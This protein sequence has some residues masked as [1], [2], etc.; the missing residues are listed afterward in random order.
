MQDY[1][2]TNTQIQPAASAKKL[3]PGA[4]SSAPH[5]EE[6][7]KGQ[8]FSSAVWLL[9]GHTHQEQPLEG[10]GSAPMVATPSVPT[11][12]HVRLTQGRLSMVSL[13]FIRLGLLTSE[14]L[15]NRE[16]NQDYGLKG[17][18]CRTMHASA[19]EENLPF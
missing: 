7:G 17:E 1:A 12:G 10:A 19:M 2:R 16:K 13:S 5:T 18:W 14:W 11:D 15:N 9:V 3:F 6:S 4:L 8:P